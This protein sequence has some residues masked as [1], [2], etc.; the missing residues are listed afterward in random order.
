MDTLSPTLPPTR[1]T[2]RWCQTPLCGGPKAT[3]AL[4]QC[5]APVMELA[6]DKV[7]GCACVNC[8]LDGAG[9]VFKTSRA[10]G[11]SR[12]RLPLLHG[13]GFRVF[14]RATAVAP[15]QPPDQ[16]DLKDP[17]KVEAATARKER[18]NVAF[19]AG[20]WALAAKK[21][22]AAVEFVQND[23]SLPADLKKTARDLKKSVHLNLAAVHLKQ[24]L[25]REAVKD[26]DKVG[27]SGWLAACLSVCLSACLPACTPVCLLPMRKE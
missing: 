1:D 26:C 12:A 16:W 20:K 3:A 27:L 15:Q 18:G 6:M 13:L 4:V 8:W 14:T 7:H 25:Y 9:R 22:K 19:K 5:G 21:Y 2:A 24:K 10:P 11:F 17:E 23:T